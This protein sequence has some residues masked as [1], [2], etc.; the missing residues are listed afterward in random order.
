MQPQPP[1]RGMF[2]GQNPFGPPSG[3]PPGMPPRPPGL[4]PLGGPQQTPV[5][6]PPGGS[7][8]GPMGPPPGFAP[9]GGGPPPGYG[10]PGQQGPPPGFAPVG[11]PPH[12]YAPAAVQPGP[13]LGAPP[14]PAGAGTNRR[15]PVVLGYRRMRIN[16]LHQ[17]QVK[18]EAEGGK[19]PAPDGGN[20]PAVVIQPV[21]PGAIVT[22]SSGEMPL[23]PGNELTFAVLPLA[24]GRVKNARLDILRNGRRLTS[25]NLSMRVNRGNQARLLMWLTL[26]LL[27]T[28]YYRW[29]PLAYG[30]AYREGDA[31]KFYVLDRVGPLGFGEKKSEAPLPMGEW[32]TADFMMVGGYYALPALVNG[33]DYFRAFQRTPL[34]DVYLIAFMLI[35]IVIVRFLE[36]PARTKVY[37]PM[38]EVRA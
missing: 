19:A 8:P 32:G 28:F 18:I 17:F 21:I 15:Q 1:Q 24:T 31:I 13:G 29:E 7:F 5:G 23:Q 25:M 22:P 3:P 2:P 35:L 33:Y 26:L 6:V 36:R 38:L 10:P 16:E 9:V 14:A 30:P 34:A 12:G 20:E 11:G 27:F 37:G 4:P